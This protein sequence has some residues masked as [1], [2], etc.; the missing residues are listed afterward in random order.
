MI[1]ILSLLVGISL[2]LSI[3]LGFQPIFKQP[4]NLKEQIKLALIGLILLI[5]LILFS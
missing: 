5:L 1:I 2:G 4:K 3:G